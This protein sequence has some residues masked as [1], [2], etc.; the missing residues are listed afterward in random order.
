MICLECLNDKNCIGN[1]EPIETSGF[2]DKLSHSTSF[3]DYQLKTPI[4]SFGRDNFQ[5]LF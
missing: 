3:G 5:D 4:S 2:G 1:T